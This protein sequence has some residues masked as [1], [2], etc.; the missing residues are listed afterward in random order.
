MAMTLKHKNAAALAASPSK[1]KTP[2]A[3]VLAPDRPR[4]AFDG[5]RLMARYED[6]LDE[7]PLAPRKRGWRSLIPNVDQGVLAPGST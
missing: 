3:Q 1:S 6:L 2:S 7:E 5:E 4:T